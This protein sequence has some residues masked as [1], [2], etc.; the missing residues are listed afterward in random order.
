MAD[1]SATLK[2]HQIQEMEDVFASTE[3]VFENQNAQYFLDDH[4]G[5]TYYTLFWN[6]LTPALLSVL[7]A[8]FRNQ[9]GRVG[10]WT[11][12]DSRIGATDVMVQF[13]DKSLKITPV[14]FKFFNVSAR[15]KTC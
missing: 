5:I 1:L 7:R 8:F 6:S 2:P 9:G 13:V 11:I 3:I 15:I 14:K 4:V 10:Q 12:N